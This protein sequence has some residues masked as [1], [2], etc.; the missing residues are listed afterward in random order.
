MRQYRFSMGLSA[1]KLMEYYRGNVKNV[2]VTTEEG[3]KLQLPLQVLKSYVSHSGIYGE[4]VVDV[5]DNNKFVNIHQVSG[6]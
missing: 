5:D 4:F 3:L 1:H 2:L 6:R